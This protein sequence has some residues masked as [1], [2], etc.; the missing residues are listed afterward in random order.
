MA[1]AELWNRT[2][3]LQSWIKLLLFST[4]FYYRDFIVIMHSRSNNAKTPKKHGGNNPNPNPNT[5]SNLTSLETM[6]VYAPPLF[7]FD[8]VQSIHSYCFLILL[9][10]SPLLSSKLYYF[11]FV[12]FYFLQL[13]WRKTSNQSAPINP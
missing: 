8:I 11:N 1:A 7:T 6:Y 9:W 5:N 2:F 12:L 3:W 13:L 10:L 4:I